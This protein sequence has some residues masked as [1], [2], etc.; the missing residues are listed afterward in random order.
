[1]ANDRLAFAGPTP[2]L[3]SGAR[4][5]YVSQFARTHLHLPFFTKSFCIHLFLATSQEARV[6]DEKTTTVPEEF[7]LTV[8]SGAYEIP[9]RDGF[10]EDRHIVNQELSDFLTGVRD[11]Y[12]ARV[13][14]EKQT[15]PKE[16]KL[17]SVSR[18]YEKRR[19]NLA[20][21]DEEKQMAYEAL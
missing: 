14:E 19:A 2:P 15:V 20:A 12:E 1:M 21:V 7:N 9:R 4:D 16:F 6:R 3:L 8:D 10:D 18:D 13:S 5:D 11:D 17:T